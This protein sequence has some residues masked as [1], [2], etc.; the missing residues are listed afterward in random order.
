MIDEE[1]ALATKLGLDAVYI[2]EDSIPE[3]ED[4]ARVEEN[5]RK[6]ALV[7]EER[8]SQMYTMKENIVTLLDCLGMDRKATVLDGE[9]IFDSLKLTNLTF[10]NQAY[11]KV[12]IRPHKNKYLIYMYAKSESAGKMKKYNMKP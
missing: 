12:F 2:D 11:M 9:D 4:M 8:E 10:S 6:M 7:K 1:R 3:K 5:R